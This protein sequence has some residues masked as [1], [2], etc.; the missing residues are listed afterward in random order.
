MTENI[1]NTISAATPEE[2]EGGRMWYAYASDFCRGLSEETGIKQSLVSSV[3]A[4]L[5]PSLSWEANKV[6]ATAVCKAHARGYE[7]E[8]LFTLGY[9]QQVRAALRCLRVGG[10][11][12]SKRGKK[13]RSFFLNMEGDLSVVT[14]DRHAASC[15]V[16]EYWGKAALSTKDYNRFTDMYIEAAGHIGI[17]PAETQAIAWVVHRRLNRRNNVDYDRTP[18]VSGLHVESE[19]WINFLSEQDEGSNIHTVPF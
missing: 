9:P 5:S 12:W 15:A 16:G 14:V 13:I 6:A 8:L 17:P 7:G 11:E 3:V 19:T 10:H 4:I 18:V 1:L 2:F